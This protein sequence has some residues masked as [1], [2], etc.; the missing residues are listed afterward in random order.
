MEAFPEDV[1]HEA[2]DE[3]VCR[4]VDHH[5]ELGKVAQQQ[6][7]ERQIVAVVFQRGLELLY[8]EDLE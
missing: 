1:R 7:P 8:G 6:N 3:E 2:V 4:G 5:C